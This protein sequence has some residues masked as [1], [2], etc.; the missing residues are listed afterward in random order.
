MIIFFTALIIHILSSKIIR[1]QL[2]P[3]PRS[4][5]KKFN[6]WGVVGAACAQCTKNSPYII[7]RDSMPLNNYIDREFHLHDWVYRYRRLAS[8][9]ITRRCACAARVNY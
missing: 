9:A 1:V 8:L 6:Q 3:T 2:P 4:S 5:K 7:Y